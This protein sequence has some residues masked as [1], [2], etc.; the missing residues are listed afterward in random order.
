MYCHNTIQTLAFL[1]S[2]YTEAPDACATLVVM[3]RSL[4]F[5]WQ[6]EAAKFTPNLAVYVQADQGRAS[7]P[8]RSISMIW[9]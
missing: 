8:A 3:P 7:I 6:R 2:L 1:K 4:L 9:C 5:N